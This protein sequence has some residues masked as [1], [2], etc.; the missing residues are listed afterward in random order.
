MSKGPI[1]TE[2]ENDSLEVSAQLKAS[3]KKNPDET[4]SLELTGRAPADISIIDSRGKKQSRQGDHVITHALPKHGILKEFQNLNLDEIEDLSAYLRD[5]REGLYNF[6]SA[7]AILEVDRRGELYGALD[8]AL[9]DYNDRRIKKADIDRLRSLVDSHIPEESKKYFH[10]NF[11]QQLDSNGRTMID[12]VGRIAEAVMT[13]YNKTPLTAFLQIEGFEDAAG[14]GGKVTAILESLD[15]FDILRESFSESHLKDESQ[16]L[17]K[18][19]KALE[20]ATERQKPKLQATLEQ[21]QGVLTSKEQSLDEAFLHHSMQQLS[22]LIFYPEITSEEALRKHAEQSGNKERIRDNSQGSLEAA[23]AKYVHVLSATYPELP[24]KLFDLSNEGKT[25]NEGKSGGETEKSKKDE[26]LTF[27]T[28]IFTRHLITSSYQSKLER[29][30]Q[31]WPT[32]ANEAKIQEIGGNAT[33][34]VHQYKELQEEHSYQKTSGYRSRASSGA[35]E[36]MQQRI[37]EPVIGF[38]REN[39]GLEEERFEGLVEQLKEL[40]LSG[41]SDEKFNIELLEKVKEYCEED[42]T[43]ESHINNLAKLLFPSQLKTF[44]VEK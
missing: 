2:R 26:A 44:G 38:I 16:A 20:Q 36:E 19:Q 14:S 29:H 43:D 17:E 39:F 28:Q 7:I 4:Q 41:K 18:A 3:F 13:F 33:A 25:W 35:M 34:L 10:D 40:D 22:G 15:D 32:F 9:D 23:I 27:V 6:I 37:L 42:R 30:A 11:Q 5:R 21:A 31:G 12:S 1:T 24:E 8:Q